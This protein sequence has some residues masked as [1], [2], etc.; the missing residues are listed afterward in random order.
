MFE[1]PSS[2]SSD[3]WVRRGVAMLTMLNE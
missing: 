3:H 1:L 2:I